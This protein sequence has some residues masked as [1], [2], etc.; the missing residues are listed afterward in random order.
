MFPLQ[1]RFNDEHLFSVFEFEDDE[2]S[3]QTRR[4]Y[5]EFYAIDRARFK[6]RVSIIEAT[7]GHIFQKSHRDKVYFDR[8]ATEAE[9]TPLSRNV[10]ISLIAVP[11]HLDVVSKCVL[12]CSTCPLSSKSKELSQDDSCLC[13]SSSPSPSPSNNSRS[14]SLTSSH[15]HPSRRRMTRGKRKTIRRTEKS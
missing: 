14:S 6:D 12:S 3:K 2:D 8:I 11:A 4:L 10:E 13:S 5:W 7:I 1:V 9:K 15:P